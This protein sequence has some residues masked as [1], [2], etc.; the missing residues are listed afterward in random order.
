MLICTSAKQRCYSTYIRLVTGENQAEIVGQTAVWRAKYSWETAQFASIHRGR[1]RPL[2][3]H[4]QNLVTTVEKSNG[5]DISPQ[6]RRQQR[7]YSRRWEPRKV[8]LFLSH[9]TSFCWLL[10]FGLSRIYPLTK[11]IYEYSKNDDYHWSSITPWVPMFFLWEVWSNLE[12][13]K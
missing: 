6:R 3:R 11:G 4:N 10:S 12:T 2:P 8:R 5:A 7:V 13:P 1:K 9:C